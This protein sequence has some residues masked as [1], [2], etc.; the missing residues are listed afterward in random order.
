MALGIVLTAFT[1]TPLACWALLARTKVLGWAFAGVLAGIAATEGMVLAGWL[2][3]GEEGALLALL[4]VVTAAVLIAGGAVESREAGV[5]QRWSIRGRMGIGLAI[6]FYGLCGLAGLG[7][8]LIAPDLGLISVPSAA[9]LVPPGPGLTVTSNTGSCSEGSAAS[10]D[11]WIYIHRAAQVPEQD[12][13][14]RMRARLAGQYGLNLV[15][16]GSGG[17]A[18]CTDGSQKLCGEVDPRPGG[19][20]I[21]LE[22]SDECES[23]EIC[24]APP[25]SIG[26]G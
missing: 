10:C 17:W 11:R 7:Y 26:D 8:A 20:V 14:A 23:Y 24:Q 3:S 19:V 18:G 1:G 15:R 16:D 22:A 13:L 6:L 12:A 4:T 25:Y 5:R 2:F 9:K 21:V